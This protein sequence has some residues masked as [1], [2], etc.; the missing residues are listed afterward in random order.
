[1]YKCLNCKTISYKSLKPLINNF[2]NTYRLSNNNNKK[3]ILLLRKGVYPYEYIDDWK[4]F[5]ETELPSIKDHY[6]NLNMK[7]ISDKDY[8]H[9]QNVRDTFKI[10]NL[11]E[12]HDLYVQSDTLLLSDVFEAFRSTC[13]KEY[14][15]DPCYFVSAPG[16]SWEACLKLT[17]VKLELLTDIDMLLMF[18]KGTRGGISQ[19][20]LKYAKANNK[21]MKVYNKNVMS[22]YLQYIDA[23]NLYGW[24]MC[25]KLPVRRFEWDDTNKYTEEMIKNYDEDGEY[26]A[27]LEVDIDYPKELH[28]L[29]TDLPFVSD[30]KIINKTSKLITS[31]ED[32]KE[33]VIHISAL[34]QALN[35]GLKLR[36]V[37]RVV[38]FIQKSWMRSYITKNTKLRNE[39]KNEFEKG[40]YKLMNNSVFGKTMENIRKHRGI[41]LVTTNNRRKK[42]VSEPNY[43]TCRRFSDHLMAIEMKKT[44]VYMNKHIY[45]GQAVLDTSK[46]LMYEFYYN[47]L[48]PKYVDKVKLCYIDTDS[49]IFYVETEDFYHDIIPDLNSCFDTSKLNNKLDRAIPKGI[50]EGILGM[51]KDELK[52]EVMTEFIALAFKVYAYMCDNDKVDKRVKGIKKC[53]GDRVLMFQHYIDALPLNKK[54]R[55]TQQRFKSDYHIITTEEVNKI[56]L[57]RKN[58]K[59]IQSFDGITTYPIRIDNDLLNELESTIRNKPI[60]MYYQE[61]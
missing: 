24:T 19:A 36:K 40:F 47:Y 25:K 56:A 53:V 48:K 39:A 16:L 43:D 41:K 33:Y 14:E 46:T 6:S 45:I 18:E 60:Q 3:F 27:I 11:G 54:I 61:K 28:E 31:F 7:G 59:R 37:H 32:K 34:K 26:G 57:S 13:I 10:K 29:H 23:N 15:L 1:M 5:N 20:I 49:F 52:G 22:S 30:R 50:N 2:S 17:K 58:D 38:S 9:V 8:V 35:H 4:R 44:K 12:Y 42:L 21:Y 51:F 55:A